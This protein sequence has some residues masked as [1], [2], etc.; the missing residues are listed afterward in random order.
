MATSRLHR[1]RAPNFHHT[2]GRYPG[3]SNYLVSAQYFLVAGGWPAA[4]RDAISKG[5]RS[6]SEKKQQF[7]MLEEN[8]SGTP[9][10]TPLTSAVRF[11]CVS[12]MTAQNKAATAECREN[13]Q[14][15][16]LD[17]IRGKVEMIRDNP[18][19]PPP[20]E[21]ASNDT[22]ASAPE[23]T[24]IARWAT[25]R[26]QCINSMRA[27]LPPIATA[28]A[29]Q[30]AFVQQ[31]RSFMTEALARISELIVALYKD[32]LTYGEFAQKRY[33]IT[34]DAV[35][36]E[37]QFRTASLMADRDRQM[38]AQQLAEQ[39]FQS[40]LLVWSAYVQAVNARQPQVVHID[41]AVRLQ[42]NCSSHQ[43]GSFGSTTCN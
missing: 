2:L 15:P 35:D 17:P 1:H 27:A 41:G 14:V 8:Q 16:S 22:F 28:N 24:V 34:R 5:K 38:Q 29:L 19:V 4:Q 18:D 13:L 20:F 21:I 36:A 6:C 37:R 10:F 26:D 12:D 7:V 33:E 31:D 9:G 11:T 40:R 23:R 25:L 43:I 42:T 3:Q 30:E 32:K 39:Q